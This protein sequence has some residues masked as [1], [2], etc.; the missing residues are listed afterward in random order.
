MY[1]DKDTS[2]KFSIMEMKQSELD[3]LAALLFE[4]EHLIGHSRQLPA[5]EC[6]RLAAY[7]EKIRYMIIY[8]KKQHEKFQI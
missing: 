6:I 8:S 7:S 3:D 2:E 1:I 4:F 5:S